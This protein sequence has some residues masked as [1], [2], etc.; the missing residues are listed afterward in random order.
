MN[1]GDP[2]QLFLGT[3]R[4]YRTDNAKAASASDVH[5]TPISGDLTSGCTGSAS[6]GA[7]GCYVSAIGVS[8]GGDGVYAGTLEGWIQFSPDAVTNLTPTWTRV[9]KGKLPNR[10]VSDIAVD[11]SND[12]IA[13]AAYNGFNKATPGH[14]GHVFLT[15]DAG[16][17]WK[18]ISSNLPDAPVNSL[19]I[20]ASYPNTIYAGTD[21]GP[22]VT[23]N[24]GKSWQVLGSGFPAVQIWQL[25]LDPANR[26][27]AAG[28]HGRGAWTMHDTA[29]VPAFV[30]SKTDA[31]VPVGPGS[32]IDYTITLHNIGNADA[33]GVTVTDPIPGNTSFT[34]AGDGGTYA[35]GTVTW[36]GQTVAAGDVL[37]LHFRV[38]IAPSL[39]SKVK[40][41]VDD[42][43]KVTSA[44]GVG[45]S[46]S[47]HVTPIAPP[48]AVTVTPAG[49]TDG[50]K[51]GTSVTYPVHILNAGFM[52]DTYTLAATG[53]SFTATVLD[54]T[55]TSPLASIGIVGGSSADVCVKVDVPGGAVNA[56]T[57]AT[58]FTATSTGSPSV[59][60]SSAITTIAVTV[61]TLLVD[62]DGN[63]PNVQSYYTAALTAAGQTYDVW[64][65]ATS[66]VL[67]LGYM[68]A[69]ATIVWFTGNSYPN[70]LGVYEP[71]LAAFLDGGGRF[72]LSGQD[73]LDQSAGT[74]PFFSDYMHVAWDG[75]ETQND[76]AT[77]NVKGESGSPVTNG[78]STVPLDLSV[79][80]GA[81]FM[82]QITPIS[83]AAVAFRD[84]ASQPDGLSVASGP[85]KVVFLA[86][87]FEGYGTAAQK[88]D[89]MTRVFTFFGP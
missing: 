10:P 75:S 25:N 31:G 86:F 30:V 37:Q 8:S 2:N 87:P 22:F 5:W 26:N 77:A 13:Y 42:G 85:Y 45:T 36:S 14:P 74:T 58:T 6:N 48:Y 53:G 61:A 44:Q 43:I 55:C 21:I 40:S 68:K 23:Y 4:V 57:S 71:N 80:G 51:A 56:T 64:D 38:M 11:R 82:D 63:G 27:L 76:K 46:G 54:A 60:G 59:G 89:L 41:I 35:K 81:A 33:T 29:Q 62:Q 49:Q 52:A 16:K 3:Y 32:A 19:Q 67:P 50:A 73:V 28:T 20:D 1:Q 24:G 65:L 17:H 88:A 39:K 72:F 47:A 9:G 70:P 83:P 78:I 79:L 66:P 69:H 18:D 15:T 84:D 7:R 12:R 34:S